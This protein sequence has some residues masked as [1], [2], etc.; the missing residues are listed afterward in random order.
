MTEEQIVHETPTHWVLNTG[1]RYEVLL[2]GVTHSTV[3]GYT[4]KLDAAIRT[5]DKLDRHTPHMPWHT[6]PEKETA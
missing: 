4:T 5:C 3:V 1:Q 6:M 2:K